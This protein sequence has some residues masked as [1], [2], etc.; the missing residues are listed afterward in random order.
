MKFRIGHPAY[1][2]ANAAAN[3][4]SY[5][6]AL[7]ILLK[8]GAHMKPAHTALQS[9]LNGSH[10]TCSRMSRMSSGR[11]VA[12]ETIEVTADLV[13]IFRRASGAA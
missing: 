8:R 4:C 12:V 2:G 11:W 7:Q 3:A 10:A 13:S 6:E 1:S 9:A 5:A